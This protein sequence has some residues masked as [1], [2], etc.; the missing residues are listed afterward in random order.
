MLLMKKNKKPNSGFTLVDLKQ[1]TNAK[2]ELER[3]TE[4]NALIQ[5]IN[6][7]F[8]RKEVCEK[9]FLAKTVDSTLRPIPFIQNKIGGKIIEVG[10]P[11][12]EM[13]KLITAI[14]YTGIPDP[15]NANLVRMN[16]DISYQ[17][18]TTFA[19]SVSVKKITIPVTVFLDN[20]NSKIQTCYTNIQGLFEKA[21]FNACT[22][23]GA[24]Y[25]SKDSTYQFGHCEHEVEILDSSSNVVLS[26]PAGQIL[27]RIDT[28]SNKMSFRCEKL[29]TTT[30]CPAWNYMAGIDANGAAKC[31]D[32]RTF[33]PAA[34]Y[35]VNTN[36][37]YS[38]INITCPA[39]MAL[40]SI[41]AGGLPNCVNPKTSMSCPPG[42]YITGVDASGGP[43]CGYASNRNACGGGLF[44]KAIDSIGNVTCG[45]AALNGSCTGY[46]VINGVDANLN[47]QCILNQP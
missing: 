3:T 23:E 35:I 29:T 5:R 33:F 39:N 28:S 45:A 7:E 6:S 32:V 25:Y 2:F 1:S 16:I 27:Q 22:G 20:N 9:N 36:N 21:V 43:T 10:Q 42:Q 26:C 24:K 17:V 41:S 37:V 34:G 19:K 44:M 38:V 14:T 4:V 40:Q 47:V 8:N 12:G 18:K 13:I 46:T 31:V 30:T 11:F 15:L